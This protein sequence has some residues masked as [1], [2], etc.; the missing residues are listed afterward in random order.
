MI[1]DF[2]RSGGFAAIPLRLKVD[3]STL[4]P[5]ARQNLE[6]LVTQAHFFDLPA[7]APAAPG[8]A[9]RFQYKLTI[10]DGA[11]HNSVEG[12]EAALPANLQPLIQQ[13][14]LMARTRRASA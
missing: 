4:E 3:T 1:I 6:G 14:S 12:S 8:G 10:Q 11:L 13:L 9:D 7:K 5:D 2:E